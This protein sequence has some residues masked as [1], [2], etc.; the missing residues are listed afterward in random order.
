M[1][2][3][4]YKGRMLSLHYKGRMLS[5]HYKGRML[6]L[7]NKGRMA[8]L[9]YKGRMPSPRSVWKRAGS[10]FSARQRTRLTQE[11]TYGVSPPA[12]F[13]FVFRRSLRIRV[14]RFLP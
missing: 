9:H 3:L 2:S 14:R 13:V 4:H 10:L 5:L 12:G 11:F 6:S 1:A 7:H 8:S